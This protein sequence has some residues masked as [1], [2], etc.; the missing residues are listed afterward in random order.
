M[1]PCMRCINP[2]GSMHADHPTDRTPRPS[3]PLA[4]GPCTVR[5]PRPLPSI[6]VVHT[7]A[8]HAH[9]AVHTTRAKGTMDHQPTKQRTRDLHIRIRPH[10]KAL[11]KR[12]ADA[13][14]QY[15]SE[16]V[17]RAALH[18]PRE[19]TTVSDDR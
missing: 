18:R 8:L 6:G 5:N 4:A 3:T 10:E 7:L 19:V 12:A 9:T 15:L 14:G 2:V 1:V 13:E 16:F 11:I 17:Q